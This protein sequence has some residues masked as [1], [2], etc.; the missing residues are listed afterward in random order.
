MSKLRLTLLSLALCAAALAGCSSKSANQTQTTGVD[1]IDVVAT[2]T[3]GVIRGIVVDTAVRPL[4]GVQLSLQAG[5]R[6]LT[7]ES[8]AN[9]GFGFQGLT[10]G[11]YFVKASKPGYSEVQVSTEVKANDNMP[12]ITRITMEA[13]PSTK[14]FV[15]S[16]VFKGFIE[17]SFTAVAVGAAA[18]AI[19]N[20]I[21]L[22]EW[23]DGGDCTVQVTE[24]VTNDK[25]LVQYTPQRV[26]SWVQSEMVWDSTQETGDQMN[27]MY[28]WPN[29]TCSPFL[30]DHEVRGSSPLLLA[31]GADVIRM[32]GLGDPQ[33][34]STDLIIRVFN[35]WSDTTAPY[36]GTC[37]P[38]VPGV[39]GPAC[40]RG[41]GATIQQAFNVYTHIFY[42][43][44][45]P[46]GYRFS[47][48]GAP[49]VPA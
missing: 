37:S 6:L 26:P 42:G 49:Q 2:P 28:S 39:I 1:G 34:N 21:C 17:C 48:D 30:C 47:K 24:N 4:Q 43:F 25:F 8:L 18:C 27:L 3:T 13:N 23:V 44:T 15:E 7:T 41:T 5:D 20:G 14:P 46:E 10:P 45:P 11:T 31:A 29:A 12:A 22:P 32:I 16:Y 33:G 19:P 36:N 9:G 38:P 35:T 40:P